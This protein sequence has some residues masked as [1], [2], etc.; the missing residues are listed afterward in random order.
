MAMSAS[1]GDPATDTTATACARSTRTRAGLVGVADGV[2][3][4]IAVQGVV[5]ATT[6]EH[7]VA[8]ARREFVVGSITHEVV[9]E[10]AAVHAF[11]AEDATAHAGAVGSDEAGR[12]IDQHTD[13]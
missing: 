12:L 6:V 5:A 1:V 2:T 13:R 3:T 7:I 4:L 11:D 9:G 8:L 10:R